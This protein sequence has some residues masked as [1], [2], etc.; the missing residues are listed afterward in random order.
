MKNLFLLFVAA[1]FFAAGC[2]KKPIV[3]K[4]KPQQQIIKKEIKENPWSP[5]E[6]IEKDFFQA[7]ATAEAC[8]KAAV[9]FLRAAA[10]AGNPEEYWAALE[11]ANICASELRDK[12]ATNVASANNVTTLFR[13]SRDYVEMLKNAHLILQ[14]RQDGSINSTHWEDGVA[15]CEHVLKNRRERN[16]LHLVAERQKKLFTQTWEDLGDLVKASARELHGESIGEILFDKS[17]LYWAAL[18]ATNPEKWVSGKEL[19]RLLKAVK[20]KYHLAKKCMRVYRM[21]YE[22]ERLKKSVSSLASIR[23][24]GLIATTGIHLR[25][26]GELLQD[27]IEGRSDALAVVKDVIGMQATAKYKM[28]M[29]LT[30]LNSISIK[31]PK[32]LSYS[33]ELAWYIKY[34]AKKMK[35]KELEQQIVN[36]LHV[37]SKAHH[38]LAFKGVSN[39][40]EQDLEAKT[41]SEKQE[42]TSAAADELTKMA[43]SNR[44]GDVEGW[45]KHLQTHLSQLQYAS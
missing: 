44:F 10:K 22:Q 20:N 33:V 40:G 9:V 21:Y 31:D 8:L 12:Y 34:Y 38:T 30:E 37:L 3:V 17:K 13:A 43:E 27:R 6:K 26:V 36:V 1:I 5:I 35:Q 32:Q 25:R 24:R 29:L 16:L 42:I 15:K 41:S 2:S 7:P 19:Q 14:P 45:V 28:K 23:L 18:D 4:E 39:G 11:K